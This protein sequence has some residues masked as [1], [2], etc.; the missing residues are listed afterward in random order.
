MHTDCIADAA[1]EKLEIAKANM[2]HRAS[3][4]TT[5]I[6]RIYDETAP[7]VLQNEEL[8]AKFPRYDCIQ[9]SLYR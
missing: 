2:R 7:E 9:S 4:E 5:S 6:K 3:H 1:D 8:A